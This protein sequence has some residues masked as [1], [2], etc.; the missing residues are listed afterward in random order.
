LGELVTSSWSLEE[1]ALG[2]NLGDDKGIRIGKNQ[3]FKTVASK[4]L[5]GI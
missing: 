3:V 1:E 5:K 4:T 2:F